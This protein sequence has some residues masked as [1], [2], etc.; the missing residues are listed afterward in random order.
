MWAVFTPHVGIGRETRSREL[1][2]TLKTAGKEIGPSPHG[3]V[4]DLFLSFPS[5]LPF[6]FSLLSL[7]LSFVKVLVVSDS[8]ETPWTVAHQVPLFIE[9]SS[10]AH[11][12]GMPFPSPGDLP[13]PG[14][15]PGS[16]ALQADSLPSEPLGTLSFIDAVSKV[17]IFRSSP[18]LLPF[19]TSVLVPGDGSQEAWD[20][21]A[22]GRRC[23]RHARECYRFTLVHLA[24]EHVFQQRT[25]E[26]QL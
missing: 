16:P 12:S 18:E 8:F 25:P 3:A 9:F 17:T 4:T 22:G 13:N 7:S 10:Q 11:W 23:S 5:F 24:N 21:G 20:I 1:I 6:C 26:H 14:I 19:G 15:E 2:R